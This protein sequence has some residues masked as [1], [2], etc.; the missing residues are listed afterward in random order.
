MMNA[1]ETLHVVS[2]PHTETTATYLHCAYTQ[3]VVKFCKMMR[4]QG[5]RVILYGGQENDADCDAFVSLIAKTEREHWFGGWD[6]NGLFGNV[7][8]S[9]QAEPWR[10]MNGRAIEEIKMRLAHRDF[11]CLVAGWSQSPIAEALPELLPVEWAVGYEGIHLKH[12]V[13]ESYAWMHHVYGLK[14]IKDGLAFDAVIPNF[15]EPQEFAPASPA[16]S[17]SSASSAASGTPSTKEDYLLFIGRIIRRKGPHVAADIAQRAGR[18]L[19]VAGPGALSVQGG[20][21]TAQDIAFGG[22][23]VEYVG[24]VDKKA[25]AELM[26]RAAAVLVPTQYL[27]PFGGVAIEAM[28]SGTPAVTTDWGAFPETVVPGVS[29][30]RF[31]TLAE[32]V[33]AVNRAVQ[34]APEKIRDYAVSRYSL[35]AVGPMF[36]EHFHRLS[37]LWG[38]GWYA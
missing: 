17:A 6:K 20:R 14:G 29:G 33:E 4:Q 10:V 3:K 28:L 24:P 19:L 38:E 13:F 36:Q 37:T 5:R 16:S 21:I 35:D 11:L 25:R 23:H 27:E 12:R 26:S 9:P 18:K 22:D 2:L 34:I 31:R 15:F 32:G 1:A 30:H 8:W 7:D